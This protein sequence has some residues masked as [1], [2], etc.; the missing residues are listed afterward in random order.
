MEETVMTMQEAETYFKRYDGYAFHMGREEPGSYSRFEALDIPT[1]TLI[2][3]RGEMVR[4]NIERLKAEPVNESTCRIF[5]SAV[6][7]MQNTDFDARI[8][9]SDKEKYA[10]EL[11]DVM[12][13]KDDVDHDNRCDIVQ[14][15]VGSIFTGNYIFF[16]GFPKL[17]EKLETFMRK[18]IKP[19]ESAERVDIEEM[20]S[21][22]L[23]KIRSGR[24]V[25]IAT[26]E[27][28]RLGRKCL[29][30]LKKIAKET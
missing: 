23:K 19:D 28:R 3:W 29:R 22:T 10:E 9:Y 4:E 26:G 27:T 14:E 12:L 13:A 24:T 15:M 25:I 21:D 11:L 1:D 20:I 5:D 30:E 16:R 18:M 2:R 8:T 17:N 6:R 7:R